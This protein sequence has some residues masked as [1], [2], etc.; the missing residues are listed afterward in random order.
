MK[1][2]LVMIG[3][4]VGSG[5]NLFV[6]PPV[7]CASE[8]DIINIDQTST[9]AREG[10]PCVFAAPYPFTISYAPRVDRTVLDSTGK[11]KY[12]QDDDKLLVG[13]VV[14]VTQGSAATLLCSAVSE[15]CTDGQPE[16]S[17]AIGAD[18][19]LTYRGLFTVEGFG[20]VLSGGDNFNWEG[21]VATE[22]F[23]PGNS[24]PLTAKLAFS[25]VAKQ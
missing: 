8:R 9:P 15:V 20:V 12:S 25:C 3:A 17:A 4:L 7:E 14:K 5:C 6:P 19:R 21:T 22:S 24:C 13:V 11:P 18:G 16:I 10:T 2:A 23:G 1:K